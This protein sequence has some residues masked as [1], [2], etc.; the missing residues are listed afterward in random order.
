MS[1]RSRIGVAG[2]SSWWARCR[3]SP[4]PGKSHRLPLLGLGLWVGDFVGKCLNQFWVFEFEQILLLGLV[5]NSLNAHRWFVFCVPLLVCVCMFMSS[6]R[7]LSEKSL[8]VGTNLHPS[9]FDGLVCGQL[10]DECFLF[11]L[12]LAILKIVWGAQFILLLICSSSN[13]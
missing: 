5:Y 13:D 11:P 8:L 2:S 4:S 10:K 1:H 3:V 12:Y 7:W 6:W 9:W